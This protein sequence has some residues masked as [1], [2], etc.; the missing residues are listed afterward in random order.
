MLFRKSLLTLSLVVGLCAPAPAQVKLERKAQEGTTR[1][2]EVTSRTE[3]KLTIAGM[4]IDSGSDSRTVVK[5]T[6]G[7]R[8]DAGNLRV[9][10]K[11]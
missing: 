9:Q 5:S 3:Q 4:E 2:T 1:S 7:K 10:E 8:D 6:I 11:V